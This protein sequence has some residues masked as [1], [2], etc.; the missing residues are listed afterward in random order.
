MLPSGNDA[1]RALSKWGNSLLCD[2][3]KGFVN[4]MNRLAAEI[5]MKNSTFA[6]PHGL[7]NSQ[8]GSTAE[9]LSILI[10]RCL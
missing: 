10:S 9:D 6:N 4:F 5:G 2:G 3:D 1:A 8:S 7:P